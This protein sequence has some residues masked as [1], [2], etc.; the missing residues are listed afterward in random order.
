VK[1]R[2]KR[3]DSSNVTVKCVRRHATFSTLDQTRVEVA[4]CDGQLLRQRKS[5]EAA[6]IEM[7]SVVSEVLYVL[8]FAQKLFKEWL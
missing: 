2:K 7:D 8:S 5:F 6:F 4:L 3:I 1:P